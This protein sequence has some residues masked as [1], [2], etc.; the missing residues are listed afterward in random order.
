MV[1]RPLVWQDKDKIQQLLEQRGTFN[2]KEIEVAVELVDEALRFPE[3]E[4][5]H[6]ACAID[7]P[8]SLAGYIC[9]GPIP[10]TDGCYD[11]YWI[12]VDKKYSRNGIGGRLIEFMEKDVINKRA[13]R[14]YVDTSSASGYDAARSFYEKHGYRLVCVLKDFYRENDHKMIYVKELGHCLHPGQQL[15]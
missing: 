2:K 13:R 5:Y 9:F 4:E 8:D 6:V 12:V 1:I 7:P 15:P 10:M 14:I 3:R 11:L